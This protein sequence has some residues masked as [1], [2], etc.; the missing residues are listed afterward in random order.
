MKVYSVCSKFVPSIET[1]IKS[2]VLQTSQNDLG[3]SLYTILSVS[4][5]ILTSEDDWSPSGVVRNLLSRLSDFPFIISLLFYSL[6][7]PS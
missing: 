7:F 6:V 5:R 1:Y 3:F 2:I 4:C